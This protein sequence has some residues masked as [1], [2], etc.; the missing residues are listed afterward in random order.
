VRRLIN[1]KILLSQNTFHPSV[2]QKLLAIA[3]SQDKK[4]MVFRYTVEERSN[5]P[6]TIAQMLI[7]N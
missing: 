7:E 1:Q 5:G 6:L 3:T 4:V 2:D